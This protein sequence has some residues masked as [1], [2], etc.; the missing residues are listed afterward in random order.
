MPRRTAIQA[1]HTARA[2]YLNARAVVDVLEASRDVML[3][4]IDSG[5]RAHLTADERIRLQEIDH[6]QRQ[7]YPPI[8]RAEVPLVDAARR[9]LA[10]RPELIDRQPRYQLLIVNPVPP[11]CLDEAVAL[12]VRLADL[13]AA[14]EEA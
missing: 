10:K 2:A 8:L 13:L 3:A 4:S 7:L 12:S 5:E 1:Y 9:V 11:G 6:A 14:E